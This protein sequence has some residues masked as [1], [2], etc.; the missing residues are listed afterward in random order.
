MGRPTKTGLDYFP[1]DVE[2][3]DCVELIEAEYGLAGFSIVIKLWQKIYKNGYHLDWN[4]DMALL[5]ARRINTE[6][7]LINNVI[8]SCL[9]RNLFNKSMFEKYKVLTSSG[10]QKRYVTACL[11]SKRKNISMRSDLCLLTPEFIHLVTEFTQFPLEESA[12]RKGKE[13]KVK[14]NI[15]YNSDKRQQELQALDEDHL[16]FDRFWNLYD[17]KAGRVKCKKLF[18]NLSEN[19]WNKIFETLPTYIQATPDK[20]YRKNPETYL[21]NRAWED[22][23]Y[24]KEQKEETLKINLI[25]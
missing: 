19:D 10:I 24:V 18:N 15:T 25:L 23:L 5:F 22:E 21:R 6:V 1:L 11:S 8:N 20:Q 16:A 2:M 13:N 7:T 12:Q 14:D 17:K 9:L 3:D 4:K